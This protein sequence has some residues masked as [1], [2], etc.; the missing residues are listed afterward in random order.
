[1]H[2]IRH[3]RPCGDRLRSLKVKP[4]SIRIR[5]YLKDESQHKGYLYSFLPTRKNAAL[6]CFKRNCLKHRYN[7]EHASRQ[8]EKVKVTAA[9][10]SAYGK[11]CWLLLTTKGITGNPLSQTSHHNTNALPSVPIF[12]FKTPS[13]SLKLSEGQED[14]VLRT[15][16]RRKL[17]KR[18]ALTMNITRPENMERWLHHSGYFQP[19]TLNVYCANLLQ[20]NHQMAHS[21]P[22]SH[23]WMISMQ[24][25]FHG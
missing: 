16:E 6:S 2:C 10:N 13:L 8:N 7:L 15:L 5:A 17:V 11:D 4:I 22:R 18:L 19:F 1:M 3:Q 14:E 23:S 12:R 9:K 24:W 21:Q 25:H 20:E